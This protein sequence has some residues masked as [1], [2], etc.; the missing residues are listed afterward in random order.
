VFFKFLEIRL[1]GNNQII[2]S[3]CPSNSIQV[4]KEALAKQAAGT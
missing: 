1:E 3:I 2:F 4:P